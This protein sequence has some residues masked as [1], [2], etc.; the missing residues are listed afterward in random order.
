ME[1]RRTMVSVEAFCNKG[2]RHID[3]KCQDYCCKYEGDQYSVAVLC[4]GAERKRQGALA[5]KLISSAMCQYMKEN[6][7]EFC[8]GSI[9]KIKTNIILLMREIISKNA[10]APYT[11]EDFGTTLIGVFRDVKGHTVVIHLGDGF[12]F[13]KRDGNSS[14]LLVSGPEGYK[15]LTYLTS[16]LEMAFHHIRIYRWKSN[17]TRAIVALTDGATGVVKASKNQVE[18]SFH[19]NCESSAIKKFLADLNPED[20]YSCVILKSNDM[21]V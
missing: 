17:K 10:V 1:Q 21:E 3:S 2:A 14:L 19:S 5:A 18:Y 7:M 8:F 15:G 20:D 11:K 4:D 9:E 6:H 12:V 13:E 16:D